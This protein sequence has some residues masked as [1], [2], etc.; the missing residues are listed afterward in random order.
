M[1]QKLLLN[2]AVAARRLGVTLVAPYLSEYYSDYVHPHDQGRPVVTSV[3]EADA[4]AEATP[5]AAIDLTDLL[6]L[7]IEKENE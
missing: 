5:P 7:P 3:A 2:T 4:D 6:P 1:R